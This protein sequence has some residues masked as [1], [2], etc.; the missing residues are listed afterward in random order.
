MD[1][2]EAHYHFTIAEMKDLIAKYGYATVI[3]DLESL[4]ASEVNRKVESLDA[5]V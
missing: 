5:E 1:Y 3:N 2:E 4:I